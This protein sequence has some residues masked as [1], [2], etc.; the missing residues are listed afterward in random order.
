MLIRKS[1]T[2]VAKFKHL[3]VAATIQNCIH[4]EIKSKLNLGNARNHAVQ[5][6]FSSCVSPK[7]TNFKIYRSINLSAVLYGSATW[8]LMLRE[9]HG[10]KVFENR[11]LRKLLG[12]KMDKMTGGWKKLHGNS[13][14]FVLFT[15]YY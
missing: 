9:E 13:L 11:M 15:K 6:I 1:I 10:V 3:R 4:E 12:P 14:T 7:N 5:N 2:N 8:S